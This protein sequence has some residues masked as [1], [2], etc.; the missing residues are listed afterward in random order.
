MGGGEKSG[1]CVMLGLVC[2][3]VPI[4][5]LGGMSEKMGCLVFCGWNSLVRM[6][7]WR[8]MDVGRKDKK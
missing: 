8:L 1:G 4:V 7:V 5:Q 2:G 3:C 6:M